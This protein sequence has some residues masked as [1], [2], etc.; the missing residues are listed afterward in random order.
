M[1]YKLPEDKKY[2]IRWTS[3]SW[4]FGGMSTMDTEPRTMTTQV[5]VRNPRTGATRTVS[6]T[7]D[8]ESGTVTLPEGYA[9]GLE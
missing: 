1:E 6:A 5:Q 2:E 4:N 3:A 9:E 7:I 8:R